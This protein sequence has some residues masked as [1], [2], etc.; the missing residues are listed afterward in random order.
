RGLKAR[1]YPRR[2]VTTYA[3]ETEPGIFAVVTRLGNSGLISR[4]P[5]DPSPALLYIAHHSSDVEL[6]EEKA[7]KEWIDANPDLALYACDVRGIGESRPDTCGSDQFLTPYG[8][9]YFYAIHS[10]MLDRPYVGQ[11]TEDVL[12]VL[13]W[14]RAAGHRETRILAKGWGASPA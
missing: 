14:L 8:S 13:D 7:I 12:R 3:V 1:E 10:L 2:A 11:K 4:P 5:Q 6:R 9:D